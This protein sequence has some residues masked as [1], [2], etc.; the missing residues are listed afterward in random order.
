LDA[1]AAP[2]PLTRSPAGHAARRALVA[3]SIGNLVEW[4]DFALY[5]AFAT[6]IA[7]TFFRDADGTDGLLAAFGVFGLAFVARPAGALLF[8]HLG[9]RVGR[10]RALT[11]GVLLMA[12][13]TAGIGALPGP[14]AIGVA[15]PVAL[16]LL[17]TLQ[18]VSVGGEY[19]GSAAFVVEH[20][21]PGRRGWYGAWQWASVG[22]GLAMGIGV[23]AALS[24][25]LPAPALQS[26]GWRLP[27]LLALPLGGVGLY[28][29][30]HVSE[31]PAFREVQL[32][33]AVSDDPL[34]EAW[35]TRRPSV[36]VGLG[37]VAAVAV[38]F[39]VFYVFLPSALAASGR[40]SLAHALG[41][42]L[43]GLTFGSLCAPLAGHLSDR[44][45][46]RPLL[47]VG[48]VVLLLAVIPAASSI[49]RG[50]AIGLLLGYTAVGLPL[51][52]LALSTFLAELFPTRLRYSGLSLTYG[53]GSAIFGGTAP[54]VATLLL[55]GTGDLRAGAW[56]ASALVA[57][58]VGCAFAA[59][60]TAHRSLDEPLV[61]RGTG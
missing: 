48:T 9:D 46:R 8:G 44:V 59:P 27:F 5:G 21:P 51:G 33:D 2:P 19:G 34:V 57:L 1:S 20:A 45:G 52:S 23:A 28:L 29:R 39:N 53:V 3:G 50:D 38:T 10:R 18:G 40:A 12:V 37:L 6:I 36:L 22:L 47:R 24:A 7:Q 14:A 26:W 31:T 13:A 15:A 41:A 55:R 32:T 4:Y 49:A 56:Y 16:V 61:A 54:L 17:R 58:A 42:A 11:A 25:A 35:R 43:V 30:T 60:E